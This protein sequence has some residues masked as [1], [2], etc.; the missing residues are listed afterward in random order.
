MAPLLRVLTLWLL[1]GGTIVWAQTLVPQKSVTFVLVHVNDTHSQFT[2]RSYALRFPDVNHPVRVSLGSVA[3]LAD[4]VRQ[5]REQSFHVL[6]LHAG[7]M[8]QGSLYYTLFHGR[9]D[10]Q[11]YNSMGLD[12][13]VAGNHEFDRGTPGMVTLLNQAEFPVLAANMDVSNDPDLA[14]RITPYLIKQ[15]DGV[16]VAVIGLLTEQLSSISS[17]SLQ[18][19]MEPVIQTAQQTIDQLTEQ[20]VQIIV[21][22]THIG[23]DQDLVLGASLTGADIIV[24]GH[25][26]TLLG[27][28]ENFGLDPRGPYPTVITARDGA[29]V[30]VVHAWEHT[31]VL[32][33][34]TVTFDDEGRITSHDGAPSLIAGTPFLDKDDQLLDFQTHKKISDAISQSATIHV[35]KDDPEVA[36]ILSR[37]DQQVDVLGKTVVGKAV[38]DLVHIR[39]PDSDRPRGSAV[40]PLVADALK[41]QLTRSGIHVDV[42]IQNAGGV[43][44][45]I[46]AGDI[47]IDTV[48]RLLPFQNTLVVFNMTGARI[49]TMLEHALE[50]IIDDHRFLGGF[51]YAAGLRF[52]IDPTAARGS[53]VS[54]CKVMA[55]SGAWQ[56]MD[57]SRTYTVAV[58][59]FLADGGDGYTVF[60]DLK[61]YDT[62]FI[63]TQ[64]FLA[65]VSEKK[66]IQPFPGPITFKTP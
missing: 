53:R 7:D 64:A 30:L 10:A 19:R 63:D 49:R 47:T 21:L 27:A 2:P 42:A 39:I 12:A 25:S 55:S 45:D 16:P 46:P 24:G 18:T 28:F 65:Y 32:G 1:L 50:S 38:S 15:V 8:V 33:K 4:R 5:I 26:H 34:L 3:R 37:Y 59:R 35:S 29:D 22:L 23:Y 56:I 51:P 43:R 58:N 20:G 66:T 44:T 9:A 11:V 6:F 48:Y 40:A 17:P 31:R 54:G 52:G 62:G 61:G 41:W 60:S 36:A 57:D 13:M 14:G